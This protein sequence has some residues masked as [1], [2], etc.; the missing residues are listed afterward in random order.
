MT[1]G[2]IERKL[3]KWSERNVIS[4]HLHAKKDKK[5]VVGWRSDLEDIVQV[6]NVRAVACVITVAN[7]PLPEGTPSNYRSSRSSRPP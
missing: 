1:V 6:F 2:D 3:G 4:R 7:L 5:T